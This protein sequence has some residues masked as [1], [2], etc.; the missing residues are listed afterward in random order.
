MNFTTANI[1]ALE[2]QRLLSG[3]VAPR[4]IAWISTI[5]ADGVHNLAPYSFFSIASCNPPILRFTHIQARTAVDK[6]TLAN[7]QA[8]QECVVNVVPEDLAEQ[9]NQTST[10]LP[11]E[12][13]EFDWANVVACESAAVKALSVTDAPVRY[14]CHLR[15]VLTLSTEPMGGKVIFLDVVSIFVRDD[16]VTQ[17]GFIQTKKLNIVGKMGRDWYNTTHDLFEMKRP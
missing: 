14:E 9:M 13:S 8:T 2:N 4:P 10:N 15:E 1:T 6:D 16:C 11:P 5:S 12:Q 7:L 3:G 17:E